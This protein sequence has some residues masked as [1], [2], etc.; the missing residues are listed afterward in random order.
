[1]CSLV[2]SS[3]DGT[4]PLLSSRIPNLQFDHVALYGE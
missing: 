4:E 3:R 2:V 1:M